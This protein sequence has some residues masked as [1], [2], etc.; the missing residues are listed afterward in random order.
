MRGVKVIVLQ[1]QYTDSDDRA[2]AK[3][4][5]ICVGGIFCGCVLLIIV[6]N[7][8][9]RIVIIRY[10]R[11]RVNACNNTRIQRIPPAQD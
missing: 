5:A 7:D 8:V 6:C 1:G 4:L 9:L 11:N 3:I 2:S 10:D